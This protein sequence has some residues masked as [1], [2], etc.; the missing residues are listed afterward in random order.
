MDIL[1]GR[2]RAASGPP[3]GQI[4]M[5]RGAWV[6]LCAG[7]AMVAGIGD[8]EARIRLNDAQIMAGVLVV[9][10][11]TQKKGETV[12]LD[13]RFT[14][15]SDHRRRFVFRIPYMPS[16][17][18]VKLRAGADTRDAV[19]ANCGPSGPAAERGERG[20]QGPAGPQG[21]AGPQ[22]PKGERGE[23]GPQGIAGPQGPK[24]E[25]G[26]MGPQ[27]IA[28]PQ[29]PKGERGEPGPQG[30]AGPQG[31]KGER[32]EMGPQGIAGPQ[33]PKGERGEMGPQGIAGLPGPKGDRGE[34]GLV[35]A[36]GE[37]GFSLRPITRE[38]VEG[39]V[40]ALACQE[41]EVA[42]AAVCPGG[43]AALTDARTI[44]CSNRPTAT[45]TAFCAR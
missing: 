16:E 28:G 39:E 44:Q 36:K 1:D 9:G 21:I 38:C 26:E 31:P 3:E 19:V 30:I 41:G 5:M 13:D 32:G 42:L 33:G 43:S 8:G 37:P 10:G 6:V 20:P 7:A 14:V 34:G 22:G 29:G 2:A 35:G 45:V 17:C 23:M 24:G 11:W 18:R 15:T 27:G 12:T 25:H 4:E 40:C